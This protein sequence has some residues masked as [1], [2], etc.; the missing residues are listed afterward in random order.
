M[1]GKKDWSGERDRCPIHGRARRLS[2]ANMNEIRHAVAVANARA[3]R[4]GKTPKDPIIHM[5]SC[6][7]NCFA[8]HV[9]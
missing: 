8:V 1:S 2:Q 4:E 6:R 7:C 3:K 5:F 9:D